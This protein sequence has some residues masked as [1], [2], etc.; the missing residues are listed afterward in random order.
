M[1]KKKGKKVMRKKGPKKVSKSF[2]K[3]VETVINSDQ[4]YREEFNTAS[5][6]IAYVEAIG[7]SGTTT[8]ATS[9]SFCCGSFAI[10]SATSPWGT[11]GSG[12]LYNMFKNC[13][14]GSIVPTAAYALQNHHYEVDHCWTKVIFKNNKSFT[15]NAWLVEC[16]P[17]QDSYLGT[18]NVG[19]TLDPK[20]MWDQSIAVMGQSGANGSTAV[21][22]MPPWVNPKKNPAFCRSWKIT[23]LKKI[24]LMPGESHTSFIRS[25]KLNISN[26]FSSRDI[27]FTDLKK[28]QRCL[29]VLVW[30]EISHDSAVPTSVNYASATLDWIQQ[31]SVK[32]RFTSER[33]ETDNIVNY[34]RTVNPTGL[35]VVAQ[36]EM[37]FNPPILTGMT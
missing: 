35:G 2:K 16:R 36:D 29:M 23:S 22:V 31:S 37:N 11:T 28:Y 20:Y 21:G 1:R 10:S 5:G 34:D 19:V 32:A 18:E 8:N 26:P 13:I 25:E 3:K 33:V 15:A 14:G 24:Q 6:A 7:S 17:R 4:P 12:D 27:S 9:K 30:G